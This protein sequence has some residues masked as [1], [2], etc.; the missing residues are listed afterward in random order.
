MRRRQVLRVLG[1]AAAAAWPLAGRAQQTGRVPLVGVL[2]GYSQDDAVAR[3][4]LTAFQQT[5]A[6]LGWG[7]DRVEI[8][9]RWPGT[10][11]ERIRVDAAALVARSPNVIL[12]SPAQVVLVLRNMTRTTPIVFANAPDPVALG[13]VQSL[14][15]PGGHITGFTNYEHD[16]AGKWLEVLKEVAPQSAKIGVLYS[17][18]NPAWRGRL[19]AMEASAPSLSLRLLPA[20]TPNVAEVGS[21]FDTLAREPVD[22][23]VVL[24]SI[25][26]AAHRKMFI[27][28]AARTRLPTVYPFPYFVADGGLVS[29]GIDVLEQYRGAASYVARI[30][31]GDMP[32]NL[33]VQTPKKFELTVNLKTARALGLTVPPSLLARA[34]EVIE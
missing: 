21:V 4:R 14:N 1:G 16:L 3:R 12:A 30:L 31:Q 26:A 8:D 25:F 22:G 9:T 13:L 34:D 32:D 28:A 27:D 11:A 15:R 18:E 17:P 23:V 7:N 19:R 5:L 20:A 29:Y 2:L 10:E 6:M 33:P 24:P